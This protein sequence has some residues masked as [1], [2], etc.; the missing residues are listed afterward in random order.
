MLCLIELIYRLSCGW[1]LCNQIVLSLVNHCL[2]TV[3]QKCDF[4]HFLSF[5]IKYLEISV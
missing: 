4:P 1:L 5:G 3:S 2:E